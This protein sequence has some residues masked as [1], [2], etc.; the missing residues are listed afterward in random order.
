METKII[1][2]TSGQG[3]DECCKVVMSVQEMILNQAKKQNI[4]TAIVENVKGELNGT[5]R[6]A[7][8]QVKANDLSAFIKEWNGTVCWVAQSPYRKYHQR[9]NWYIGISIFDNITNI[10][11][12]AGDVVFE[13]LRSSGPGG[14][15]VNKVETAVRGL[16]QPTGIQVLVMDT[17][18]QLQ[19]K[20]LCLERLESIIRNK[21]TEQQTG[22]QKMKW[23]NHAELNRGNP[24]KTIIKKL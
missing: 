11:W 19:N 10:P 6:S 9:K 20:K 1:Q 7:T 23:L 15:H 16:H 17:R 13:T 12:N 2:I 4:Q 22:Q 24:V 8:I 21:K 5:L 14:Q 3:P 18:S